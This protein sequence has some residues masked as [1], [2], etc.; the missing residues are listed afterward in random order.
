MAQF[1][2]LK[3]AFRSTDSFTHSSVHYAFSNEM[4][5]PLVSEKKSQVE[6]KGLREDL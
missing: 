6:T 4:V 3:T 2:A 1:A 5:L